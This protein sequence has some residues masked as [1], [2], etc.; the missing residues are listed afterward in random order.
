MVFEPRRV[1]SFPPQLHWVPT[2]H[3]R[4]H[5][6]PCSPPSSC[7][8][9]LFGQP[10]SEWVWLRGGGALLPLGPRLLELKMSLLRTS[11]SEQGGLLPSPSDATQSPSPPCPRGPGWG[12]QECPLQAEP[13]A[14]TA[15]HAAPRLSPALPPKSRRAGAGAPT[16]ECPRPEQWP[17]AAVRGEPPGH[18]H[19]ETAV[20][21]CICMG[22]SNRGD[23]FTWGSQGTVSW[24][25]GSVSWGAGLFS[26]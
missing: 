4:E 7:P 26:I 21:V 13:S 3:S 17:P 1:L 16:G 23:S 19:Q 20:C 5:G 25:E 12:P 9:R 18:L 8:S 10:P 11:D 2:W 22:S 14:P 15:C 6:V 24:G